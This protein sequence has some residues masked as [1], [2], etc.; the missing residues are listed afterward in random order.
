VRSH[1]HELD[2]PIVGLLVSGDVLFL[3]SA[4]EALRNLS[5]PHVTITSASTEAAAPDSGA[6]EPLPAHCSVTGTSHPTPD[7][8]IGFEV[9][10]PVG[11]AWNGRYLQVGNGVFA[12]R[13]PDQFL[14]PELAAGYAVAGTDDGHQTGNNVRD[15]SWALGPPE[16]VIDFGYRA[17]KETTDAARAV[18]RAYTGRAPAHSNFQ[19]CS[20][21][22]REAL[23]EAQRYPEDFDGIVAGAPAIGFAHLWFGAA[24]NQ[25][26]LLETPGSYIP[27]SKLQAIQAAAAKACG[28]ADGVIDDPLACHFGPAVLRCAGAECERLPVGGADQGAPPDLR[29]TEEPAKRGADR[30][31]PLPRSRVELGRREKLHR[32]QRGGRERD[33]DGRGRERVLP[34]LRL[35]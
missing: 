32:R 26:A 34:L 27:K 11:T 22:G 29:R 4:C 21:G 20:T 7:S 15:A 10:I 31:G 1:S 2:P 25:D 9:D 3:P 33:G 19:G 35:R 12:G 28:D 17:L 5:L 16:K 8:A 23:T 14:A 6:S 18:I 30:S 24:W 13:I